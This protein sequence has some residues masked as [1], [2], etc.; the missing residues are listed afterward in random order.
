MKNFLIIVLCCTFWCIACT[1]ERP[2]YYEGENNWVQF[3]YLWPVQNPYIAPVHLPYEGYMPSLNSTK[4]QDTVY[5]RLHLIG[6]KSNQPRKV[7]FESYET[8]MEYSY[9]EPA[10]ANVNYIAFDDPLMKPYL[11]I[12]GDSAYVNIPVIVK[13]NPA[14]SSGYFQLDFKLIDTEVLVVGDTCLMKGRLKFSQ[15]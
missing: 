1:E 4:L 2:G 10:V 9:Y 6:R 15:W 7:M 11:T 8:E 5:F 14:I 12:P 3:Y 13:Y